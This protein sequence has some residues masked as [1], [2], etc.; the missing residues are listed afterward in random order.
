MAVY[1]GEGEGL[2]GGHG[3]GGVFSELGTM[4]YSGLSRLVTVE[5]AAKSGHS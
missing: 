3:V 2:D 1:V 5:P 4:V